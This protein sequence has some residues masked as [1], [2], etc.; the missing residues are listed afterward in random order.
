MRCTPLLAVTALTAAGVITSPGSVQAAG[1]C[2]LY[3]PSRIS[4]GSSLRILTINE[5]PNCAAAAVTSATWSAT[6]P[7]VGEIGTITFA[8]SS[9]SARFSIA[10]DAPLGKWAW[11]PRGAVDVNHDQVFQ[12]TPATDGSAARIGDI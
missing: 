4:I 7:V 3:A 9:R 5:G 12:Y 10:G 11:R 8:N 2:S 1:S 6:H